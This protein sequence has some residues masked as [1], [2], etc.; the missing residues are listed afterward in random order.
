MNSSNVSDSKR[1]TWWFWRKRGN[2]VT[3]S[4]SRS[5]G[6]SQTQS[7]ATGSESNKSNLYLFENGPPTNALGAVR[8]LREHACS[9][10][11]QLHATAWQRN[12]IKVLFD[13]LHVILNKLKSK[14]VLDATSVRGPLDPGCSV[15][16]RAYAGG[17]LIIEGQNVFCRAGTQQSA[18]NFYFERSNT[19]GTL[20][21]GDSIMIRIPPNDT[22]GGLSRWLAVSGSCVQVPFA[23]DFLVVP[24]EFTLEADKPGPL[25]SG[26]SVY[27]R[28]AVGNL[29][30]VDG[31]SVCARYPFLYG[32]RDPSYRF[33]LEK[34]LTIACPL[35]PL[36]VSEVKANDTAWLLRRGVEAGLVDKEQLA[37]LLGGHKGQ[38]LLSEFSKL[39]EVE[40]RL[41]HSEKN[42]TEKEGLREHMVQSSVNL[43][44]SSGSQ[45]YQNAVILT[46]A[47]RSFFSGAL[48]MVK[49]EAN[50]VLRIVEAFATVLS[51][52]VVV[53]STL[54]A[55]LL[56]NDGNCAYCNIEEVIFGL[57][58]TTMM[59]N[60]DCHSSHVANKMWYLKKF[61]A[62][63][64]D[65][66]V[67]PDLMTEIFRLVKG[68]AI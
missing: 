7:N 22:E 64:K 61:T 27:L 44:S 21:P 45:H 65:C 54:N 62:A 13:L 30:S 38:Q 35:W 56:P 24:Q 50:Y 19:N 67:V 12:K 16:L 29:V 63:H 40:W 48:R 39:W 66:G 32:S 37:Q 58:Y 3:I 28:T 23:S 57:T 14:S 42:A 46:S 26:E 18:T 59:L 5:N 4:T 11:T 33:V 15:V 68:H 9:N 41:D 36:N 60:T 10:G 55:S 25:H 43:F 51:E 31:E 17:R 49:C 2:A 6:H 53:A 8:W 34:Q 1:R 47:M 52:D 20:C